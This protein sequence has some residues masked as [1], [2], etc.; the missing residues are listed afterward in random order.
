MKVP[1]PNEAAAAFGSGSATSE[2]SFFGSESLVA[3][4]VDGEVVADAVV[5]G[6]ASATSP[7]SSSLVSA[8]ASVSAGT[9]IAIWSS[10]GDTGG[11][12]AAA[13]MSDPTNAELNIPNARFRVMGFFESRLNRLGLIRP[14]K[15]HTND[16]NAMSPNNAGIEMN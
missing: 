15:I 13:K 16:A 9:A 4:A 10:L 11:A 14:T 3:V 8:T 7:P 2:A 6:S 12:N 1:F 5:D